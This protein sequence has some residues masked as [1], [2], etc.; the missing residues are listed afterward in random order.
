MTANHNIKQGRG[1][2]NFSPV[3][4]RIIPM[5]KFLI[6]LFSAFLL[7]GCTIKNPFLKQP[8]GLE[9][10]ST[11]SATVIL[12]DQEVGT[13]PFTKADLTP[14]QYHLK[15]VPQDDPTLT[16]WETN[17]TLKP[18]VNTVVARTFAATD[19]DSSGHILELVKE[20]GDQTYLTVISDPD[21]VNL[22]LDGKPTGYTPVAKLETT[23]G[24]HQLTLSSP[25]Y[26]TVDL[27][28]NAIKG[29]NLIVNAKLATEQIKLTSP[30]PA[31]ESGSLSQVSPS[32]APSP[33]DFPTPY[34]IVQETGTGWLRVRKEP[35]A[36]GAELGKADVGEK[37]SYLGETTDSGWHQV[38]FEGQEG[39][40][41][42]SYVKLVQ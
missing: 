25:G 17:L 27:G 7:G 11:P 34:V 12:N 23:P 26:Q 4:V 41:S 31:T 18:E 19:T 15:L 13:T 40:L 39:W 2:V 35:S 42:A 32:P 10:T 16:A 20:A 8:A 24:S 5:K 29:Y 14:G 1:F 6:V 36:S 9:I 22:N 38:E 28:V 30:P 3:H 37:L 33:S 21:T